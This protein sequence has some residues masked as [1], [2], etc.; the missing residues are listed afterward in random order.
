MSAAT[1]RHKW[2]KM[3]CNNISLGVKLKKFDP[4]AYNKY[5]ASFTSK[6]SLSLSL[7][8]SPGAPHAALITNQSP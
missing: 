3:V 5:I 6:L 2:V 7:S 1:G 4:Q 8:L